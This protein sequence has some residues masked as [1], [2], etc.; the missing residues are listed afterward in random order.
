[1]VTAGEDFPP[2]LG[3]AAEGHCLKQ[4]GRVSRLRPLILARSFEGDWGYLL[5][6]SG[7][8]VGMHRWL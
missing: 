2:L 6:I 7:P 3:E 1:M 8:F 4:A 5:V